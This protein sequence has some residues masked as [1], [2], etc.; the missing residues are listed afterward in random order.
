MARCWK[1]GSTENVRWQRFGENGR[2]ILICEKCEWQYFIT[3]VDPATLS[4][5]DRQ[6]VNIALKKP[7]IKVRLHRGG[8]E[9][10]MKTLFEP[11]DWADFV[12]HCHEVF[13]DMLPETIGCEIYRDQP[14]E[15]IGWEKTYI[16]FAKD[17][18]GFVFPFA[19]SD[20]DI[21]ILKPGPKVTF[22]HPGVNNGQSVT[23]H[24]FKLD[25][26]KKRCEGCGRTFPENEMG[27]L[28]IT[29]QRT[30]RSEKCSYCY[31]CGKK[32]IENK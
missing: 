2:E 1:C 17:H 4:E 22:N 31:E 19:F 28:T 32:L 14:D 3:H 29:D 13:N 7:G 9:E 21:T 18:N 25:D 26:G 20:Q 10:S 27:T 12:M 16:I 23:I 8:L 11:R 24:G 30:G 5:Q 15:R 6:R